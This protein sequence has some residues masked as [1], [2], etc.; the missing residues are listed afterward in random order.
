MTFLFPEIKQIPRVTLKGD[1]RTATKQYWESGLAELR[2]GRGHLRPEVYDSA[3]EMNAILSKSRAELP[4]RCDCNR[5]LE[6][7]V[8]TRPI[9]NPHPGEGG[10]WPEGLA[11]SDWVADDTP[12]VEDPR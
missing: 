5:Y 12:Y 9:Y 11:R 3:A 10:T 2:E 8:D 7:Q 6:C 1:V 4:P